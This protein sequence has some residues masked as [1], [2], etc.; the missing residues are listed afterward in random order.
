M[1]GRAA[2]PAA[3]LSVGE[4]AVCLDALE[5]HPLAPCGHAF[6]LRCARV[7]LF[8]RAK[9]PLCRRDVAAI[10]DAIVD[11]P[12]GDGEIVRVTT[13]DLS[14]EDSH[15]GVTL[16][17]HG[18]EGAVRVLRLA[19]NDRMRRH[20]VSRND[21]LYEINGIRLNGHCHAVRI[22]NAA[23][24]MGHSLRCVMKKRTQRWCELV[25]WVGEY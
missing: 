16:C 10:V 18:R 17:D 1:A 8:Q 25:F 15:A 22:I 19:P 7:A 11:A 3:R 24:E 14:G 4:C 12:M 23:T 9:C 6:C 13:I 2:P 21:V 20:G 5:L